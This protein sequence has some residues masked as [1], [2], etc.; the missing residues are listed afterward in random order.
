MPI[1]QIPL[2]ALAAG[3]LALSVLLFGDDGGAD[4]AAEAVTG[5]VTGAAAEP[6]SAPDTAD[7]VVV[8]P[9]PV[10]PGAAFS[11]SDSGQCSGDTAEATFDD[12]GIPPLQLAG[13]SGRLGGT[14]ILPENT[15]PGSYR[16]TLTCGGTSRAR[17]SAL[18]TGPAGD[19]EDG[20]VRGGEDG[21]GHGSGRGEEYGEQ[22]GDGRKT[23]TGTMIVSGGAD[24]VV[25]QGGADTGLGGAAGTGRVATTAGGLLL[26]A[27]AGWGAL[28]RRRHPRGTGS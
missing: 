26:L 8:Q 16:V 24:G 25:P 9:D 1:R 19:E 22:S 14:A 6:G 23:L 2:Y 12:A 11:V 15:A 3:A 21:E 5:T 18:D 10:A 20:A 4:A 17:Q 7:A 13:R 27:A 28:A